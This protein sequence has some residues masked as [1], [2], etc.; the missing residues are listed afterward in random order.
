MTM[1]ELKEAKYTE[2]LSDYLINNDLPTEFDEIQGFTELFIATYIDREIGFETE[3]LFKIKLQATAT[4]VIPL[5]K[6]R[7]ELYKNAV[8]SLSSPTKTFIDK[9][10]VSAKKM[11]N[12]EL[13]LNVTS[14]LP[15]NVQESDAYTDTT[16]RTES[17]LTNNEAFENVERLQKKVY[18]ITNDLLNEFSTLF[19]EVY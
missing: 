12:T 5:Y 14:A 6:Q 16:T 11:S 13:P 18:N 4:D 1:N 19:M 3:S 15:N 9:M 8:A 2:Y 7:I 17:G 10:D